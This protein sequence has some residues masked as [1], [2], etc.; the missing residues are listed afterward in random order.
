MKCWIIELEDKDL[1]L[2]VPIGHRL[3]IFKKTKETKKLYEL[4][5]IK[6]E[7]ISNENLNEDEDN[8][9]LIINKSDLR[10]VSK[11]KNS[12]FNHLEEGIQVQT[13]LLPLN[14]IKSCCWNCLTLIDKSTEIISN[15]I[16]DKQFCKSNCLNQYLEK[17]YVKLS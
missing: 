2:F 17:Y 1:E 16:S 14:A 11:K 13:N 12:L 15:L 5:L 9:S 3:K 10:H 7:G 4:F 8:H 6:T